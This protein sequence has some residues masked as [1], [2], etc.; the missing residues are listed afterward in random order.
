MAI[1]PSVRQRMAGW[2]AVTASMSA[3]VGRV[4][5][6]Q[7]VWSQPPPCSHV[8]DLAVLA[9]VLMRCCISARDFVP[10][11]SM[12][13]FC[14]PAEAMWVWASLKPGMAKAPLRLMILVLG[15]CSFKRLASVPTAVILPW[16]MAIAVTFAGVLEGSSGRR[17][18]PVRML[19]WM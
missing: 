5:V 7:M 2:P 16:E 17:W 4:L 10:S 1:W 6:G 15:A 19:P 8:P 12:V 3:R 14:W 9:K 13:S 18:D 11:R